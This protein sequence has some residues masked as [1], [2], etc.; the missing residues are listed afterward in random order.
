MLRGQTAQR[1]TVRDAPGEIAARAQEE[2]RLTGHTQAW[3]ELV[4]APV[5]LAAIKSDESLA[6]M[7]LLKRSRLSVVPVTAAEFKRVLTLGKTKL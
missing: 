3:R 5:T 1:R 4:T 6:Q 2:Y 7:M